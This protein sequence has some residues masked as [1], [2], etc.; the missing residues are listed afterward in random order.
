MPSVLLCRD[1]R[2]TALDEASRTKS[3]LRQLRVVHEDLLLSS[4]EAAARADVSHSELL[5]EI[6]MKSFELTR[7]QVS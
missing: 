1:L 3:E 4:R 7:L 2:D 5:G 6:K